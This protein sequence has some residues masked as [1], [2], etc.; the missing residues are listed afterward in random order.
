M[1]K[2]NSTS[3]STTKKSASNI[4]DEWMNFISND[5]D[6]NDMDDDLPDDLEDMNEII[7]K[8]GETLSANLNFEFNNETP[9]AN[10]IYIF[11]DKETEFLTDYFQRS[12]IIYALI[13]NREKRSKK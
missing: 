3:S 6:E 12:Q 13:K 5:C 11:L 7:K 2:S 4:E 1:P 9:K 8:S 10:E